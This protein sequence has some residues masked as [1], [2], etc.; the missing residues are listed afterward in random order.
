MAR[1]LEPV[2]T[3]TISF[4]VIPIRKPGQTTPSPTYHA[5]FPDEN[6][7]IRQR[8]MVT[9]VTATAATSP[10]PEQ[11]G[12]QPI[13]TFSVTRTDGGAEAEEGRKARRARDSPPFGKKLMMN[14][15]SETRQLMTLDLHQDY[16]I[17]QS[18]L[19]AQLLDHSAANRRAPASFDPPQS[20]RT[21]RPSFT[22]S[23]SG[24]SAPTFVQKADMI[25]G[26][27]VLKTPSHV[28][29]TVWL[30]LPDPDSFP[31]LAHVLY[32]YVPPHVRFVFAFAYMSIITG[33]TRRL[34][35]AL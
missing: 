34:W 20:A 23:A 28:P 10:S 27:K 22:N 6:G 17:S 7:H 11:N 26:A 2:L 19:F 14:F 25:R 18:S 24:S 3:F 33:A 15:I 35:R 30:P 1:C 13:A 12:V 16:L 31:V 29:T 21:R 5:F 4:K 9:P 8:S 32:W